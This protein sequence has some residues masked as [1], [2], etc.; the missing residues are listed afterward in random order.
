MQVDVEEHG[1]E[2]QSGLE[3][4][5]LSILVMPGHHCHLC[6]PRLLQG[7]LLD[8]LDVVHLLRETCWLRH[9]LLRSLCATLADSLKIY[10]SAQVFSIL[11][12]LCNAQMLSNAPMI[13]APTQK[14]KQT[15][16]ATQ[17]KNYHMLEHSLVP[18]HPCSSLGE[19]L[20]LFLFGH[21][22]RFLYGSIGNL[23][24]VKLL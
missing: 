21:L 8:V 12:Y 18:R 16:A 17:L 10:R 11:E 23:G 22:V 9:E 3:Q 19:N 4:K 24:G 14:N 7:Q 1:P 15:N 13:N 5:V 20:T 6:C 2:D